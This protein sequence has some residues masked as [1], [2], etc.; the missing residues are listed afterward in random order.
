MYQQDMVFQHHFYF[1]QDNSSL[2]YK[3]LVKKHQELDNR[4]QMDIKDI[5]FF[6][7]NFETHHDYKEWVHQNLIYN[8]V[9]LGKLPDLLIQSPQDNKILLNN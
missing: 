9:Q 6:Q 1:L 5:R 3:E 8:N 4:I 7:S 2:E